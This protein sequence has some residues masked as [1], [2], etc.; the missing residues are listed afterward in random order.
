MG[1]W[2]LSRTADL[3]DSVGWRLR[4]R[5]MKAT[6]TPGLQGYSQPWVPLPSRWRELARVPF[7][8][9]EWIPGMA[10]PGSALRVLRALCTRVLGLSTSNLASLTSVSTSVKRPPRTV[11]RHLLAALYTFSP[12]ALPSSL[13]SRTWGTCLAQ[14][15]SRALC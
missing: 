15:G 3:P 14:N 13:A 5:K 11:G 10:L 12:P 4:E 6:Q 9:V 2:D 7:K 1:A 8:G